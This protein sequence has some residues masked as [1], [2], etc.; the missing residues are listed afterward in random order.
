M[1]D[2]V[3]VVFSLV[4]TFGPVVSVARTLPVSRPGS[5]FETRV[6]HWALIVQTVSHCCVRV[7]VGCNLQRCCLISVSVLLCFLFQFVSGSAPT[8]FRSFSNTDLV[9]LLQVLCCCFYSLL[10]PFS[11]SNTQETRENEAPSGLIINHAASKTRRPSARVFKIN[12]HKNT[13]I[14]S[15]AGGRPGRTLG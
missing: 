3:C 10:S 12:S 11:W 15:A 9:C 14:R 4:M 8:L 7:A 13:N 6:R 1:F 2:C 5:L